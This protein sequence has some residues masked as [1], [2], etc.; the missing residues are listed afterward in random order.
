MWF[1]WFLTEFCFFFLFSAKAIV[2]NC[3]KM[4]QTLGGWHRDSR[5]VQIDLLK[6]IF[7]AWKIAF[8]GNIGCVETNFSFLPQLWWGLQDTL[9]QV[10]A[11]WMCLTQMPAVS[12]ARCVVTLVK[13]SQKSMFYL[14]IFKTIKSEKY[15]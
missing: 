7:L 15:L 14:F 6:N 1:F 5:N 9:Y 13:L 11:F 2:E 12:L 10:P 8:S 4:I 3:V